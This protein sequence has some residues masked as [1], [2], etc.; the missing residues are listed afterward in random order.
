MLM[1]ARASSKGSLR[2]NFPFAMLAKVILSPSKGDFSL[3]TMR[4]VIL[5]RTLSA[6]KIR[7]KDLI[8]YPLGRVDTCQHYLAD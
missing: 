2:N 6:D 1:P 4:E 8:T 7:A 3:D 5:L